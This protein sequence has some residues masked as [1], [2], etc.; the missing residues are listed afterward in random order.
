MSVRESEL[1][2]YY[3]RVPG[4]EFVTE[5][6]LGEKR[7]RVV[8]RWKSEAL[9]RTP[10][11]EGSFDITFSAD[12]YRYKAPLEA[13]AVGSFGAFR[14]INSPSEDVLLKLPLQEQPQGGFRNG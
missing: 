10:S 12:G 7:E 2:G 9:F 6:C 11:E 13:F 5:F 3:V 8:A 1:K 4:P 14:F